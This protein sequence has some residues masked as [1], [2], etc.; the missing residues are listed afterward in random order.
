MS[1]HH[2]SISHNTI[3]YNR[4]RKK[5]KKR[6]VSTTWQEKG[7]RERGGGRGSATYQLWY[8]VGAQQCY[9]FIAINKCQ[10]V[11]DATM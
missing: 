10:R 7:E 2:S 6:T 1:H 11:H 3:A 9:T 8:D 4:R 5:I